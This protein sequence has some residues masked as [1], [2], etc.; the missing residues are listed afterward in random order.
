MTSSFSKPTVS[1]GASWNKASSAPGPKQASPPRQ[2][3]PVSKVSTPPATKVH[4]SD[5]AKPPPPPYDELATAWSGG[6]EPQLP[7]PPPYQEKP[8]NAESSSGRIAATELEHIAPKFSQAL[9]VAES[10]PSREPSKNRARPQGFSPGTQNGTKSPSLPLKHQ[11]QADPSP[12]STPYYSS[13]AST[14]TVQSF[15]PGT[16]TASLSPQ[17]DASS[18]TSRP[19]PVTVA[20]GG[21]FGLDAELAQKRE[22]NYDHRAEKEAQD[23]IEAV[24]GERFSE[25]FGEELRNG[26][27]LCLLINAIKPGSVRKVNDS[28]MPFKQMENIS[29][30]LKACRAV[31]V[32]EHSLFETVDLFE[33]KDLGLVVRCVVRA[34]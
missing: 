25:D 23:W 3:P 17:S 19:A 33:G 10:S 2:V 7:P 20:R 4:T 16:Q 26:R 6:A 11:R 15:S 28:R 1:R 5:I 9:S 21:G 18:V 12:K 22:A 8:C 14:A 27:R 31:G 29:N 24:T 13:S 32:A 34:G 30:F